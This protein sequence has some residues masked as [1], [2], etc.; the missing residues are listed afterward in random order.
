MN[1]KHNA[2]QTTKQNYKIQ[3]EHCPMKAVKEGL[4]WQYN[5]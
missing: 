5:L 4:F 1:E 2:N 3:S